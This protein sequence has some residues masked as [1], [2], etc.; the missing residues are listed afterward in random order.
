MGD[1]RS[2]PRLADRLDTILRS[3]RHALRRR[4][5]RVGEPAVLLTLLP[6]DDTVVALL[7]SHLPSLAEAAGLQYMSLVANDEANLPHSLL[8][9]TFLVLAD[10]TGRDEC[11]VTLVYQALGHGRRVLLS[12]RNDSEIPRDLNAVP[13]VLYDCD[14]HR[15]EALLNVVRAAVESTCH[16]PLLVP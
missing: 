12:A 8:S 11:V 5:R 15:W 2:R 6:D 10:L 14:A 13:R 7:D 16:D 4:D 1:L 9:R 3:D